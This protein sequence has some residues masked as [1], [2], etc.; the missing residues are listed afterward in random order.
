V[1]RACDIIAENQVPTEIDRIEN[2][3]ENTSQSP[4][5]GQREKM[6]GQKRGGMRRQ[7]NGQHSNVDGGF[8]LLPDDHQRMPGGHKEK[9]QPPKREPER[10]KGKK[11]PA[12]KKLGVAHFVSGRE[13]I[14]TI[15]RKKP[16]PRKG[17]KIG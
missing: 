17:G 13:K 1:E 14:R 9:G 15:Y 8:S 4:K 11:S 16:S 2:K 12:A 5:Q 10:R 7:G 3:L 6:L